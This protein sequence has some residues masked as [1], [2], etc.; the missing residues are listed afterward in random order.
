MDIGTPWGSAG[1]LR[2]GLCHR[3]GRPDRS[4]LH[5]FRQEALSWSRPG[6]GH[7]VV[8]KLLMRVMSEEETPTTA[9]TM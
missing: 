5:V 2:E 7:R 6:E 4:A 1:L 8:E 3:A 9:G